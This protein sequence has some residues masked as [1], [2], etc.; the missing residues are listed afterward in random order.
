MVRVGADSVEGVRMLAA[1]ESAGA[2]VAR[3]LQAAGIPW[4]VAEHDRILTEALGPRPSP[5]TLPAQMVQVAAE[6]RT[7]LGDP[8]VSLDSPPKLLRAELSSFGPPAIA[9]WRRLRMKPITRRN[10]R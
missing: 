10:T 4:D 5:G 3:E 2:L 8:T 6:V 1:A 9:G 7:A